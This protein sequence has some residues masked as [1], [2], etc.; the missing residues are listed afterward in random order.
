MNSN[1]YLNLLKKENSPAYG[2]TEPVAIALAVAKATE[3]L[4]DLPDR[5]DL[6]LSKNIFKN[7]NS[8]TIPATSLKGSLAAAAL[9]AVIQNPEKG[10]DIFSEVN[11]E[12]IEEA[13]KILSGN[14][15]FLSISD[16][17]EKLYIMTVCHYGAN[18]SKVIVK[19][20]HDEIVLIE[21]N[22]TN[23]FENNQSASSISDIPLNIDGIINFIKSVDINSLSFLKKSIK[24]NLEIAMEGLSK[25]NSFASSCLKHPDYLLE[26]YTDISF[27]TL[28]AAACESRMSGSKLPVMTL[29]GSG[30]QGIT[31]LLPVYSY[32]KKEGFSEEKMLRAIALSQLITIHIK[33]KMGRLSSVCGCAIAAATGASCAMTYMLGGG[34]FEIEEA[35]NNMIANLSGLICDGAKPSCALKISTALCGAEQCALAAVK[36]D[37]TAKNTG[38]ISESAEQ[39][40]NNLSLISKK[41]MDKTEDMIFNIILKNNNKMKELIGGNNG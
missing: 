19:N 1:T 22:G 6:H 16:A 23:L 20:Y 38:I 32:A 10:L 39:S 12:K 21:K 41:G 34:V 36:S 18:S 27:A 35:V 17:P 13:E 24:M 14:R 40:I 8:V 5:I 15:V 4:G 2:C 30:N 37:F 11:Q 25:N 28:A 26:D 29:A 9:G 31:A 33:Q 3:V 7:A